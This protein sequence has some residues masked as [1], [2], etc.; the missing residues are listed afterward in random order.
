[1]SL[2]TLNK[3]RSLDKQQPQSIKTTVTISK[4]SKTPIDSSTPI[5]SQAR[6]IAND[7]ASEKGEPSIASSDSLQTVREASK[8]SSDE[9]PF[10][11]ASI[12]KKKE[13]AKEKFMNDGTIDGQRRG[14]SK[15]NNCCSVFVALL[16]QNCFEMQMLLRFHY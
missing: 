10:A 13:M 8:S 4:V 3:Q 9:I 5:M 12:G 11:D 1:M 7:S 2:A 14:E 16:A 15:S 6:R